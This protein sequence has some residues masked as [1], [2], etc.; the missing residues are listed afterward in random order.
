MKIGSVFID[1]GAV[2]A[3][4]AGITNLPFRAIAKRAGAAMVCSEM[5]S[6]EGLIRSC[7]KTRKLVACSADEKPL[8]VQ[9]FGSKPDVMAEA[10]MIVESMGADILDV[11][12]GCSVRKVLR[13]GAGSA[14]MKDLR[15]SEAILK[16]IRK[17]VR[18]PL[19]I[20]IRSGWDRSGQQAVTLSLIAQDC[21]VDAICVH[22]RTAQQGF[23][24]KSDWGVIRAVKKALAIPVLGNGDIVSVS[25]ALDMK[26]QTACDA[27][28]IGRAAIG[29]P[30]IF[31]QISAYFN[32]RKA[33]L[34]SLSDHFKMIRHYI[35]TS[36]EFI[37]EH[38]ACRMMRSRIGW[39]FKHFPYSSRFRESIKKL[40]SRQEAMEKISA[41]QAVLEGDTPFTVWLSHN[42]PEQHGIRTE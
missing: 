5:V 10:G 6:S 27:V 15:R 12:F 3:P 37:G 13:T 29:N 31:S 28:M 8:S 21:G 1:N 38:H 26:D 35:D 30:W 14:L 9:I 42:I 41:Y 20:K 39:F 23:S 33:P 32:H 19:T 11:N 40:Q 24:G 16:A 36:V 18:I 25:D 7:R 2:L 34:I 22:P 4:L 17:A